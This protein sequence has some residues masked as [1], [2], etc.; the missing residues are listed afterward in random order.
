MSTLRKI[1]KGEVGWDVVYNNQ[2][3]IL[4]ASGKSKMN[5]SDVNAIEK[6]INKIFR[7]DANISSNVK[8]P[9]TNITNKLNNVS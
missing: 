6:G 9:Y 7:E 5:P 2:E 1:Y 4:N 3:E 8:P